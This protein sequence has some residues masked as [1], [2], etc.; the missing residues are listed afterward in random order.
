MNESSATSTERPWTL[1]LARPMPEIAR[2]ELAG[3]WR[4]EDRLP[5]PA[6][7]WRE[8]QAGPPVHR[9][10]FDTSRVTEWDSGLV[11]FAIKVLEEAKARGIE[12]DRAGLPEGAQRLLRLA[13]AVPERHTGRGRAKPPVAREDRRL[14]DRGLGRDRRRVSPSSARGCS[15]SARWSAAARGSG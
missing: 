2:I 13:E 14:G 5:D 15:R 10:T 12:S 6:E 4:N 9:L 8:I 3:A 11:T 1:H 7:V